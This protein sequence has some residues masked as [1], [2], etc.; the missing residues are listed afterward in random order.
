MLLRCLSKHSL[1]EL[2]GEAKSLQEHRD[3]LGWLDEQCAATP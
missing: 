2:C 3:T 1:E